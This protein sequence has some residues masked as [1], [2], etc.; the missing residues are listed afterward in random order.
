VFARLIPSY[1]IEGLSPEHL[2]RAYNVF[3]ARKAKI[4]LHRTIPGL[5]VISTCDAKPGILSEFPKEIFNVIPLERNI[6]AKAAN[7]VKLQRFNTRVAGVDRV[8]LP[9]KIPLFAL[10]HLDQFDPIVLSSI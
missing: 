8:N 5:H 2:T 10:G 7:D 3:D 6:T 1:T 9:P 4:G